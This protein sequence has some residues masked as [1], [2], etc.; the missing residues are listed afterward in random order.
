MKRCQKKERLT[1][2][3]FKRK[4]VSLSHQKGNVQETCRELGLSTSV[5][6]RWRKEYNEYGKN[7]FPGRVNPKRTD[8]QKEIAKLKK[9]LR[10]SL[11]ENEILKEVVNIY[12][13]SDRTNIGL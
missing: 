2:S 10:E 1:Q 11:L 6:H 9:Q 13:K 8:D 4:A 5:L 3:R 12:S 7:S